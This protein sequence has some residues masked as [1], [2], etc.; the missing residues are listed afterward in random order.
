VNILG[1]DTSSQ[2]CVVAL[3]I[4][5]H[6]ASDVRHSGRSHSRDILPV[7]TSLLSEQGVAL[8]DL[9]LIVFGQGPGSFTGLRIAVG[10]VQGLAFGLDIP[11]V[12][13]SSLACLAQAEFG[14]CGALQIVSVL[15]ARKEEVYLG[16]Y[17]I[18]Q[19]IAMLDGQEMVIDV[20][21]LDRRLTGDWVGVGDGW[22]LREQLQQALHVEMASVV[23]DVYPQPAALLDLGMAG[24]KAGL[25]VAAVDAR[26]EYLREEVASRQVL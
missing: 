23:A 18:T 17:R 12:P 8:G 19:G 16:V 26:P 15:H 13:V 20:K 21:D 14:R 9:D 4:G 10:V 11:V 5:D 2:H 7:I 1:I 24:Y 22:I 25:A 3:Q 6:Q